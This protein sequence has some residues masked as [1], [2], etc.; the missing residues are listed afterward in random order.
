MSK[1]KKA[2]TNANLETLLKIQD[3]VYSIAK[4]VVGIDYMI[5]VAKAVIVDKYK[6]VKPEDNV[7]LLT[8]QII[9]RLNA[10][11][12]SE[13]NFHY[14][15]DQK[16]KSFINEY[17]HEEDRLDFLT[18]CV[19]SIF[20]SARVS[21][22]MQNPKVDLLKLEVPLNILSLSISIKRNKN[23]P[24]DLVWQINRCNKKSSN[25]TSIKPQKEETPQ[26]KEALALQKQQRIEAKAKKDKTIAEQTKLLKTAI[27]NL[28]ELYS[29][30]NRCS[31][32]KIP[33]LLKKINK[34]QSF[35]NYL[36]YLVSK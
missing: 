2:K 14:N 12:F 24:K 29:K 15:A 30:L 33:S 27:S 7:V 10:Y 35:V 28:D 25:K 31:E 26:Q 19:N 36:S 5:A 9:C 22:Y 1:N 32:D 3:N 18:F 13:F 11:A 8:H 17:N 16:I 6:K 23:S 20:I 34:E 21:D 4:N